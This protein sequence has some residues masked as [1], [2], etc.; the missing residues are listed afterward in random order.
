MVVR[1]P[2]WSITGESAS[3]PRWISWIDGAATRECVPQFRKRPL[4]F[5]QAQEHQTRA[6]Q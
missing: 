5:A 2:E 1:V 3:M 4:D 6:G